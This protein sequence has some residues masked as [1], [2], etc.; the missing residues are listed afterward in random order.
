MSSKADV[1]GQGK[2][3]NIFAG[4][5]GSRGFALSSLKPEDAVADYS[6]LDEKAIVVLT[7]LNDWYLFFSYVQFLSPCFFFL[8]DNGLIIIMI[9]QG[10][11]TISLAKFLMVLLSRTPMV[12]P[13]CNPPLHTGKLSLISL[14]SSFFLTS[15]S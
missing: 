14:R 6:G 8:D 12:L 10:N 5:D 11:D 15:S 7:L 2:S 1:Y 4:K 13:I 3:Y 9:L